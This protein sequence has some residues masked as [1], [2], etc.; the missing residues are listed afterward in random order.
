MIPHLSTSLRFTLLDLLFFPFKGICLFLDGKEENEEA[1]RRRRS[2]LGR[3]YAER[4][5]SLKVWFEKQRTYRFVASSLFFCYDWRGSGLESVVRFHLIDF[6]RW[7]R[8]SDTE[9]GHSLDENCLWGLRKL[10]RSV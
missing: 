5:S 9:C 1:C 7:Y 8:V 4:I 3:R 6:A 10:H 2:L